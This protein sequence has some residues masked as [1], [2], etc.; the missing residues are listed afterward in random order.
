MM[1]NKVA[2]QPQKNETFF[3]IIDKSFLYSFTV[4]HEITL[5]KCYLKKETFSV[6]TK[7]V[8]K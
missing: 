2:S 5:S 6:H 1:N 3:I 7:Y 4:I 8:S